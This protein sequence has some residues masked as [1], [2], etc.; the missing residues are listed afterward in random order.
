[1]FSTFFILGFV[2]WYGAKWNMSRAVAI[3]LSLG[4]FSA[5]LFTM[6]VSLES[7]NYTYSGASAILLS[8]NFIPACYILQK[9]TVWK[10]VPLYALFRA[11]AEQ[12]A[13][14]PE[15][16]HLKLMDLTPVQR[17]D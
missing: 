5:W 12:V 3:F 9:K 6:T 15:D 14:Q 2:V 4:A 13:N 17:R 8:T 1:M 16:E 11:L 10:D 7:N